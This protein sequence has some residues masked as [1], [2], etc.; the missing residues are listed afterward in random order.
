MVDFTLTFVWNRTR[1]EDFLEVS[2]L[3]LIISTLLLLLLFDGT[4]A[5]INFTVLEGEHG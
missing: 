5:D 3:F 2:M 4:V 1:N